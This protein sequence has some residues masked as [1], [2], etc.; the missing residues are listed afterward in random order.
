M[1]ITVKQLKRLIKE[2][3]S[4]LPPKIDPSTHKPNKP[5]CGLLVD[6]VSRSSY[7]TLER[8]KGVAEDLRKSGYD[9]EIVDFEGRSGGWK[10]FSVRGADAYLTNRS[11]EQIREIHGPPE[12]RRAGRVKT[13]W[14][15][16]SSRGST[17]Y[18]S[19]GYIP[20]YVEPMAPRQM[21]VNEERRWRKKK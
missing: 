12:R 9:V 18:V 14:L 15:T 11:A 6:G 7:T 10:D 3:L 1:R 2:A 5:V 13:A 19:T 17:E 8:A 20:G 21:G 4:E 16:V